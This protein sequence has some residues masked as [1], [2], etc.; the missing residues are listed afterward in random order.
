[1]EDEWLLDYCQ[2]R[3]EGPGGGFAGALDAR[4]QRW[5]KNDYRRKKVESRVISPLAPGFKSHPARQKPI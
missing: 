5:G 1:M 2:K 3:I 4:S